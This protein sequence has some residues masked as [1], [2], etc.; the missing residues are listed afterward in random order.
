MCGWWELD[1]LAGED[2]KG[3][4]WAMKLLCTFGDAW[5]VT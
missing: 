4:R 5:L 3:S 2:S 1:C